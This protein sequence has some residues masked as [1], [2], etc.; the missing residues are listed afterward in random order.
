[1]KKAFIIYLVLVLCSSHIHSQINSREFNEEYM[2]TVFKDDF[3][4]DSIKR[5]DWAPGLIH[6]GI[7]QLIDSSLT[8]SVSNGKLGLTMAYIP[9]YNDSSNFVGGEFASKGTF[10]YGS[11]E[12]KA[13]FAKL[14]GSWPAFWSFHKQVC[15]NSEGPEIDFAEYKCK[16]A[17]VQNEMGHV[18]HHWLDACYGTGGRTPVPEDFKHT[19]D[20]TTS[21]NVFK[22]IWTPEKI[23][24]YID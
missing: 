1:M 9:N 7:G 16:V 13:T 19:Y 6:R 24:Y 8:H 2:Y 10:L 17:N 5:N 3:N 4:G 21:T 20:Y 14:W 18:I 23:E 11:F 12:C 22:C 15:P